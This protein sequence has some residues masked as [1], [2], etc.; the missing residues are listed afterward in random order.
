MTW[1]FLYL[2]GDRLSH[3]ELMAA[4]LDGDLVEVG[5]AYMPADAVETPGLR[6]GSLRA[7]CGGHFALTHEAAA[8]VHG[9]LEDPPAHL[10]VQRCT[11]VRTQRVLDRRLRYRDLLLPESDRTVLGGVAVSIPERTLLDLVR[12]RVFREG[13]DGAAAHALIAWR[14]QLLASTI[15][16]LGSAAPVHFKRPTLAYLREIDLT[17]R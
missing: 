17:T 13:G 14:P 15:A 8:W 16:W 6:A 3:P 1:P 12:D 7:V 9:A 5:D 10:N 2:A 11:P 4:R